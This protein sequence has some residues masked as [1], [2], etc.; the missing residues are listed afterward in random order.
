[1]LF[2][3]E[4]CFTKQMI[5]DFYNVDTSTINRYLSTH[6]EELRHNGFFYVRVNY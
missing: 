3:N 5:A 2:N 1:M 6:D 4:Y